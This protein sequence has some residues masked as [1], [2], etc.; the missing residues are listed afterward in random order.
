MSIALS[1]ICLLW[2][3]SLTFLIKDQTIRKILTYY[4]VCLYGLGALNLLLSILDIP[5]SSFFSKVL[6]IGIFLGIVLAGFGT[7][8]YSKES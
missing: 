5:A 7:V 3:S 6:F 2:I 8:K 1:T 4:V